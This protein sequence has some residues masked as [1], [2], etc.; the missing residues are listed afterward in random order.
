MLEVARHGVA[1]VRLPT[2]PEPLAEIGLAPVGRHRQAARE[3]EPV[4]AEAL[5]ELELEVVPRQREWTRRRRGCDR[6]DGLHRGG[7]LERHFQRD[8]PAER[9]ADGERKPG[10][11][12]RVEEHPLRA[13]LVPDA[14]RRKRLN[15]RP[16]GG[17]GRPRPRRSIAAPEQVGAQHA[18]AVGVEGAAGT[19]EGSP[20]VAGGVG[21]AGQRMDH[22]H[23]WRGRG[24]PVVPE[25]HDEIGN[26]G[27]ALHLERAQGEGLDPSPAEREASANVR[28]RRRPGRPGRPRLE[29]APR[30][31]AAD[32]ARCESVA[33]VSAWSRS[34]TRSSTCSRPM[35]RRTR[36]AVTPDAS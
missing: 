2:T 6:H 9:P 35:E 22:E 31:H 36:S 20:P 4:V 3:I 18:H 8:H 28:C 25:G 17:P 15:R 13:G 19:D 33:A 27:P 10:D 14:D 11:L 29:P 12:E 5:D 16:G 7:T 26:G 21:R 34:A 30:G 24:C 23:L 32:S 1:A